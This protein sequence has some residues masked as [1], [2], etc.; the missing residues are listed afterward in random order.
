[1]QLDTTSMN[2]FEIPPYFFFS[3]IGVVFSSCMYMILLLKFRLDIAKYTRIF[4]VSGAG[5]LLGA[6]LFGVFTGIFSAL[7]HGN[8]LTWDTL[9]N[10]GI[11]F[12]GGL[13][14]FVVMYLLLIK[15]F[16]KKLGHTLVDIIAICIPLFHFFGRLG[17]YFAGCCFGIES[18]SVFTV[19]YTNNIDGAIV[20]AYR[21]PVQIF[22]ALVN[23]MI[24]GL[25][26]FL[27]LARKLQGRLLWLYFISYAILRIVLE[28]FRGDVSRGV[29]GGFTFSQLVSG[30]I[31]V[32]CLILI[33]NKKRRA[34]HEI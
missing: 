2:F 26:I 12:Y 30:V 31:V 19:L 29:W 33:A 20:T 34:L 3:V 13:I 24:F 6:R 21:V 10:T 17:C 25:I 11:V 5:L 28:F 15:F 23:L 14:G 32:F 4:F 18:S 1:M 22:E 8:P 27:L 16:D 9:T 7:A